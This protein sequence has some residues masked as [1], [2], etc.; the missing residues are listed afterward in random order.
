VATPQ[1]QLLRTLDEPARALGVFFDIH[2]NSPFATTLPPIPA[3]VLSLEALI[4]KRP[5]SARFPDFAQDIGS[6]PPGKRASVIVV[7][8]LNPS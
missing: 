2:G 5:K 4:R 1:R 6:H 8:V 7:R 3:R